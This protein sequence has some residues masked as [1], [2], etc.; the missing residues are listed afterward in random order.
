MDLLAVLT[1][2]D[3][4][5]IGVY[6]MRYEDAWIWQDKITS[7][8]NAL[9]YTIWDLKYDGDADYFHLELNED[10]PQ[11]CRARERRLHGNDQEYR[12]RN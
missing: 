10:P 4:E 2:Q 12:R 9:G 1:E 7:T 11:R 3:A 5:T 6:K 8:V